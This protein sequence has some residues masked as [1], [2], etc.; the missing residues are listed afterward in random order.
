[1]PPRF[2]RNLHRVCVPHAPQARADSV[3]A[4]L[5]MTLAAIPLRIANL[6]AWSAV[7]VQHLRQC[8]DDFAQQCISSSRFSL[9]RACL[10]KPNPESCIFQLHNCYRNDIGVARVGARD[11]YTHTKTHQ[12]RLD[13]SLIALYDPCLKG[14]ARVCFWRLVRSNSVGIR[15]R[16][17]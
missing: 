16:L 5:W 2:I 4:L 12:I 13:V 3:L 9:T 14:T 1:M 8:A 10:D 15:K 6:K 11:T 7:I 17:T